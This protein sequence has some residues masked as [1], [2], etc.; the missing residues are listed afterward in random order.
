M[1]TLNLNAHQ[2]AIVATVDDEPVVI[3]APELRLIANGMHAATDEQVRAIA[4]CVVDRL[5]CTHC[6]ATD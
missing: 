2:P 1:I 3:T 5:D 4:Q 6:S